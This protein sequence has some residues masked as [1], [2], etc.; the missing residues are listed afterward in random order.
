MS[1]SVS[2][3][4]LMFILLGTVCILFPCP[5]VDSCS[6]LLFLVTWCLLTWFEGGGSPGEQRQISVFRTQIQ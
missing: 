2:S 5:V 6:R 4:I 3:F 1:S